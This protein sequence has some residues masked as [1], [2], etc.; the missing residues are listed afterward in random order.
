MPAPVT[1][2]VFVAR[3]RDTQLTESASAQSHF[4]DLCAL[5]GQPSPTEADSTG[6]WYTF[7]RGAEK[8]S[9]GSG[10]A[11]VWKRGCFAWEYKGPHKDLVKAYQQLQL[12]REALE[13]PPLLIVSDILTIEVHTNFTNTVK[14]VHKF[15]LDDLLD[16]A[17]LD[18][19]RWIFT[20][21]ERFRTAP[22]ISSVT[23][24]A[25]KEF[26]K[27]ADILRD[28]GV[29]PHQAA[30]YLIRLLFCLFAEDVGLLPGNTFSKLVKAT[31]D[32]PD[33]FTL[34]MR[35]LFGAMAGGGLFGSDFIPH[36][37]G[38]LFDS[39]DA[40]PLSRHG[41]TV[42]SQAADL[43]WSAVEPAIFGTLFER[44]LDPSKRSQ[45]G[46]HYTGRDDILLI[47]EP[48]LM[49]PLRQKWVRVRT[50]ALE[51]AAKRDAARDAGARTRHNNNLQELLLE[52]MREIASVRVL[53]GACGSGNFL[54]VALRLLLDLWKEVWAFM[55]EVGL[56]PPMV[57]D[58]ICPSP[59]QLYGIEIDAY[60]H[61]LAQVTIW[62]GYIQWLRDNGFGR[63]T[64]PILKP[65]TTIERRDALLEG[66]ADGVIEPNWPEAE[67]IIG[68]PPFL[69]GNKIRQELGDEYVDT[70]FRLYEGRVPAFA[71]L[72]C[73]WFERARAL[74][75]R[76]TAKRAGLLATQ[77]I[78]GG[79]NRRVL[80]R[81]KETGDIFWAQSDRDWV[82][83]G[84]IVHVS[85][86]GF[87]N[88]AE[89]ERTLNGRSVEWIN[90][91]LTSSVDVSTA[92]ALPENAGICFMGP[93]AK[94]PFDIE[95]DLAR[96]M[97]EAPLNVNG[98]P[99]S[100]VV[101][102]VASGVDLVRR[103]RGKWTIDFGLMPHDE[104]SQYELPFEYVV[105]HVYPIRR[106]NRRPAYAA[107]W[108]QYAEARPGMRRALEG[109][110]RYIA[111]PEVAKHRVFVWVEPRVL[112]N[113][114]TLV[115][116]RDD[117]YF[118]GVLHS[119]HHELWA[120][121]LGTQLREV[122]SGFRY[123]PTT[124]FETFPFPWLP[125][126]EP[127]EDARVAAISD[128]A[129]Q[130][131]ERRDWWLNPEGASEAELK[132]RTLTNLYNQQPTWLNLVHERLD[133]AVFAAYGWPVDL[134][135]EE[136]LERL[137][138]LN[139]EQAAGASRQK[140]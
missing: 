125:G 117:D 108:W 116:A 71:D 87:D 58:D 135:D 101:R 74:I 84:A 27:L 77:G 111:T 99:N 73:Y 66:E 124:T 53:D 70:L 24:A 90:P 103:S 137:L 138:E 46:A 51:L 134:T 7:E 79:A 38:K 64:E 76:G 10:W 15:A 29:E 9:G 80:E 113:Q 41:L 61:E 120:R 102:P 139:V 127:R 30:R 60:A 26:A 36:F 37:D 129:K 1:P 115:F 81:I 69:G 83:D 65:I 107:K 19:L 110:Y 106:N 94:A 118:F 44:S 50:E 68:N 11:D 47:V 23:E 8:L 52:F 93:S 55:R 130:L 75:E 72:V 18:H 119:R 3:W 128:A 97:L 62:I 88:G 40:V 22:T 14:Q 6:T 32:A 78:R 59:A 131:V 20:E 39:A 16:P 96:R 133:A 86:V 104:A 2:Q 43:D 35:S 112:C 12:Y 54:Y 100:D 33:Q 121:R 140:W 105:Q 95:P 122:E 63:P 109:K 89:T 49:A 28:Q 17:K 42:L 31:K 85:M 67:V 132:K 25:A 82:L 48:V 92:R 45:L 57:I 56:T 34:G 136:I 126:K 91:D 123:T 13:N 98:R 21:P 5:L 4:N 114:Q